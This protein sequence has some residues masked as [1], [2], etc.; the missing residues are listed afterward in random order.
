MSRC[1]TE[2]A[3]L[4]R[5]LES[6]IVRYSDSSDTQAIRPVDLSIAVG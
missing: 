5:R 1:V 6:Q 3:K 2:E 4:C